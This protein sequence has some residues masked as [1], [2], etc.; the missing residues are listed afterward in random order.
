M[1]DR[2]TFTVSG[3]SFTSMSDHANHDLTRIMADR[4]PCQFA[5][6][7]GGVVTFDNFLFSPPAGVA[8]QADARDLKSLDRKVIPVRSRSPAPIFRPFLKNHFFYN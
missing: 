4:A 7:T 2:V 5:D 1:F 8:K 6:K 3:E